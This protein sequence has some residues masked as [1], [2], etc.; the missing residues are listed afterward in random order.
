[1]VSFRFAWILAALA[2]ASLVWCVPGMAGADLITSAPVHTASTPNAPVPDL[3]AA[4]TPRAVVAQKLQLNGLSPAE[5]AQRLSEMT[6]ADV[7]TLA[8]SPN[9]VQMA[10][11]GNASLYVIIAIVAVTL[12]LLI[13]LFFEKEI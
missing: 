12:V 13:F 11:F 7:D 5:A 4:G 2:T 3:G 8:G 1:M 6:S 10:G 9:Q